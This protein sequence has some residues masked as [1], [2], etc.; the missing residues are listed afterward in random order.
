[1][2]K[3]DLRDVN[4]QLD[5]LEALAKLFKN[6]WYERLRQSSTDPKAQVLRCTP[7]DA[8]RCT[9]DVIECTRGWHRSVPSAPHVW[10]AGT[11]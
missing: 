11:G 2:N 7:S 4:S 9:L 6:L 3:E 1:M 5:G 8:T 10:N